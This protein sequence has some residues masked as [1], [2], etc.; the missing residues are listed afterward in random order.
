MRKL[1]HW[2]P[3]DTRTVELASS[4]GL[5]LCA[6]AC[7]FGGPDFG[8]ADPA[9]AVGLILAA[10]ALLQ[11]AGAVK[12]FAPLRVLT[13]FAAGT[14]WVWAGLASD[15]VHV[16]PGDFAALGLGVSCLYA[17]VLHGVGEARRG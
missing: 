14:W 9:P 16:E 13:S 6:K 7:L 5:A 15:G 10:F 11:C 12:E 8:P 1:S 4:F 17:F 2:L 3:A